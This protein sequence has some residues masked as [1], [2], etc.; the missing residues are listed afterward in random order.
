MSDWSVNLFGC[1]PPWP[2]AYLSQ[3]VFMLAPLLV[4][5]L[6]RALLR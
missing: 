2:Q 3:M 4:A 5:L 6:A 1:W